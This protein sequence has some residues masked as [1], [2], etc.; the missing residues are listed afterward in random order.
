M[1][2]TFGE[3]RRERELLRIMEKKEGINRRSSKVEIFDKYFCCRP[4]EVAVLR[5]CIIR[6]VMTFFSS[7]L[8]AREDMSR[9]KKIFLLQWR[10]VFLSKKALKTCTQGTLKS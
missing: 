8:V 10:E 7:S 5:F 4:G 2:G 1:P 9:E 6:W 3:R